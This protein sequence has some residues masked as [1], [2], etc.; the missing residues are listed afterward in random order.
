MCANYTEH[1]LGLGTGQDWTGLLTQSGHYISLNFTRVKQFTG[2][3][4][5]FLHPP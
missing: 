3:L 4:A 1:K 2:A 5:V